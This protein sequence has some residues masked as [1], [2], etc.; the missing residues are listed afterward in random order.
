MITITDKQQCCGCGAC[1]Q[2]CPKQCI[3]LKEDN[4]GFLYPYVDEA[5]CIDCGLCDKVCPVLNPY[6]ARKPQQVLAAIN[7]DE[8]I[9]MESSSGGIFTLLAEKVINEG[10]VVFGA[11]FDEEWQVTL[12]YTETIEGLA[13][14][15]GSKYV[16]ARTGE[17]YNQCEQ[18]LKE[19]RKVLFTGTPCQ[20]AGLHHYL[21]RQ[22]EDLT[23]CDFVC[24]GVP[25]PKVWRMY[26]RDVID[27]AN[28]AITDIQF[29]NKDNG[30]KAFKFKMSYDEDSKTTTL[31]SFN[32]DNLYMRAFLK[33][34]ILRPSCYDC[35]A[36]QC[37][38]MAD[39][40]IADYWGIQVNH[41]EMD[42]DKGTGLVLVHTPK[43]QEIFENLHVRSL[44]TNYD[45]VTSFNPAI[46]RSVSPH[47][48]RD[49]FF[50]ELD[51]TQH[52]SKLI[53]DCTK[54]SRKQK[55]RAFL[56]LPKRV[57]RKF[58]RIVMGGGEIEKKIVDKQTY[59]LMPLQFDSVQSISFRDK[60]SGWQT[61][62][63]VINVK[64]YL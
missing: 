63:M 64:D 2:K 47:P 39:I 44:E 13:A 18:F 34:M 25:S 50:R 5:T 29:R 48:N 42:D 9:R 14:F 35:K 57:V 51:S 58:M 61:Y 22:Y 26:L 3:S 24:H 52:L 41:P 11:R 8:K 28:R 60:N 37:R 56:A 23:T 53:L 49:I 7:K 33:D 19:G 36:K 27:G 12:D 6:E 20:I 62:R 16:Q 32:G 59:P 40:T 21:R 31:S 15:R 43:G 10:G 17:T 55:I 30:W 54:P 1:V 4:E 45:E 38:S 46:V